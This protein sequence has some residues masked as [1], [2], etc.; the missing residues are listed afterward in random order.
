MMLRF[1]ATVSPKP[2]TESIKA[3]FG[4]IHIY[5]HMYIVSDRIH[6]ERTQTVHSIGTA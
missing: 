3:Q 4:Y 2:Q 5:I 1:L 6:A